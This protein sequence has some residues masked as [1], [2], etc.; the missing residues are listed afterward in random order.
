MRVF[1]SH[2]FRASVVISKKT[3]RRAVDRHKG[4]RKAYTA[5][6]VLRKSSATAAY[7]FYPN[8]NILSEQ[9][10]AMTS[11]FQKRFS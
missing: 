11:A 5:L 1:P 8:K 2:T 9:L 10:P 6:A 3:L 4:K 7:V